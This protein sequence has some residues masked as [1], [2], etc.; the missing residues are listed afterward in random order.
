MS[1]PRELTPKRQR[2]VE[3]YCAC[4]NAT[5]AAIRAGYSE[6]TA[7]SIGH[8]LLRKPEIL[9]AIK[10]RMEELCEAAG[11]TTQRVMLRLAAWAFTDHRELQ[12]WGPDA[13][14]PCRCSDLDPDVAAC[15]VGVKR[16]HRV[17]KS[18]AE[19]T[20]EELKR[21]DPVK[22]MELIGRRLGMWQDSVRVTVEDVRRTAAEVAAL[23]D[24]ELTAMVASKGK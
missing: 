7:Y 5:K 19:V 9:A 4:W 18:G 11:I 2:F 12:E 16:R 3:E 23:T 1:N 13:A 14:P 20:E 15:V 6:K 17:F 10:Q 24:E 8:E 21:A 22:A